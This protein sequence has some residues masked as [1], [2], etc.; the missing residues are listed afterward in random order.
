M[1]R[2]LACLLSVLFSTT[3]NASE[4]DSFTDRDLLLEDSTPAVNRIINGYFE[5]AVDIANRARTCDNRVINKALNDQIRG[6]L[7]SPIEDAITTSAI[8][9][10][11]QSPVSESVYQD[12]SLLESPTLKIANLGVLIRLGR[13]YVGSDKLNHFL[14]LG[15]DLFDRLHLRHKSLQQVMEWSSFTEATYYGLLTTGIYSYGD[16]AANYDGLFFWE[17]VTNTNLP[18][19]LAPYLECSNDVWQIVSP[20][21]ISDYVT[22]AWDEGVNCNGYKT[23]AMEK[24]V[25]ARIA[26]LEDQTGRTLQ[27][28]IAPEQCSALVA[29]YGDAARYVIS[30]QCF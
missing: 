4:I 18:K 5:K 1:R 20:F 27:C 16:L 22:A 25:R 17:R 30:P 7:W 26:K 3:Q 28:P 23:N 29:H 14:Q 13:H 19:G 11:R 8:I 10:K 6:L 15:Y 9:D 21:D 24:K 12:F 2:F